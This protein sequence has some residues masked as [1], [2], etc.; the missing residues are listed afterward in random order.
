M[1]LGINGKVALITGASQGIGAE[2]AVRLAQE[3]CKIVLVARRDDALQ[4]IAATLKGDFAEQAVCIACDVTAPEQIIDAVDRA[5]GA[6]G[7]VD[8][9]VNNAGGFISGSPQPFDAL[10]DDDFIQSYILNTMSAVRFTRAV[11]PTMREKAWGRIVSVSSE[12]AV[13]PDPVGADYSAS[14]AALSVFSKVLSRTEGAYG[15]RV[16]VVSPAFTLSPLVEA[17]VRG[18]GEQAGLDFEQAQ[19]SMLKLV[20]PNISVGRAS[21]PQE[22][23]AAVAFLVSEHASFIN[24]TIMRVDGGSVGSLG[25]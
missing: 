12:T 5:V 24:G 6:F 16:N 2:I 17:M 4:E 23:A 25:G 18:Y 19:E 22:I 9:L 21:M 13:Q 1:D 10:S 3:G 14:K 8:I 20:R 7:A 11:L 15:I